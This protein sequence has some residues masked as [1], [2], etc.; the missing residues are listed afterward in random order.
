MPTAPPVALALRCRAAM[1]VGLAAALLAGCAAPPAGAPPAPVTA[2]QAPAGPTARLLLRGAVPGPDRFSAYLLTD[3]TACKEP[4]LLTTGTPQSAPAPAA[5]PVG[6]PATLAFVVSRDNKAS[7]ES[8]WSFTPQAGKTY[9]LAGVVMGAGCN[10]RLLDASVPERPAPAADAVPRSAP[11]QRCLALA[12][13]RARF[14]ATASA[15]GSAIQGGQVNGEAVLN[16][17][18]TTQDLRWLIAP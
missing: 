13:A 18:A 4:R 5:L 1:A 9:L 11:G 3:G 15:A 16:P 6:V 14:A 2:L 17:R 8:I 10:V 12:E 7:C